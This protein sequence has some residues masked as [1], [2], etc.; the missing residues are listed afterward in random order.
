MPKGSGLLL[1]AADIDPENEV[2]FN[3]WYDEEHIAE[4]LTCPGFVRA[5][6][7]TALEGGP[8]YLALYELESPAA[9]ETDFYKNLVGGGRNAWTLRIQKQMK[10]YLR[11][12]YVCISD[13]TE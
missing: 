7:F 6:R 11:N 5:R 4:R 2:D 3:R 12:T 1:V 10:N 9:L 8:K 13:R